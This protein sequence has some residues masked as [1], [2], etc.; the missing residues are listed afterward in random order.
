[1]ISVNTGSE[2]HTIH[3]DDE[4]MY[5]EPNLKKQKIKNHVNFKS[6]MKF[7]VQKTTLTPLF[8]TFYIKQTIF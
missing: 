6:S 3:I 4:Y 1:M 2:T 7:A 5:E 8:C